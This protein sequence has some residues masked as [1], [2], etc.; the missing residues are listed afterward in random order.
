ML[1]ERSRKRGFTPKLLLIDSQLSSN[2]GGMTRQC[3][4]SALRNGR[5]ALLWDKKRGTAHP[6]TWAITPVTATHVPGSRER[7]DTAPFFDDT[8]PV[9]SRLDVGHRLYPAPHHQRSCRAVATTVV[10]W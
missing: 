4:R 8:P 10:E 2:D 5:G 9:R 3:T 6:A 1:R 7:P